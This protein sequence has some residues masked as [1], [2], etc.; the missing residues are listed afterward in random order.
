[1]GTSAA[2]TLPRLCQVTGHVA[3]L[4]TCVHGH[5]PLL[6]GQPAT[7]EA[8]LPPSLLGLPGASVSGTPRVQRHGGES[9]E[10]DEPLGEV[11]VRGSGGEQRK[12]GLAPSTPSAPSPSP[13]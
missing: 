8:G 7:L 2:A 10:R 13:L 3:G 12:R 9:A 5:P 1:M 6:V 11:G 4:L